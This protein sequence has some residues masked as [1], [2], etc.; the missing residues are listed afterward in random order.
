LAEVERLQ[1]LG[2][3]TGQLGLVQELGGLENN[4]RNNLFLKTKS[5]ACFLNKVYPEILRGTRNCQ[6][7]EIIDNIYLPIEVKLLII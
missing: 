3:I 6:K 7:N 1:W 5:A 4:V 2:I